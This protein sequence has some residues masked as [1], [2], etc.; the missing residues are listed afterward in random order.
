MNRYEA[1]FIVDPRHFSKGTEEAMS[2]VKGM[3]EKNGCQILESG[4]WDERKL[5]YPI[6]KQKKGLYFLFFFD[7]PTA[8]IATIERECVLTEQV[9]RVLFLRLEGEIPKDVFKKVSETASSG[10]HASDPSEVI[11]PELEIEGAGALDWEEVK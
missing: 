3:L 6:K 1:M 8:A 2:F 11:I 5:C 10:K 9:L 7:A 4:R